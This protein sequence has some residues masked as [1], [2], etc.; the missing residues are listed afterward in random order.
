MAYK[1]FLLGLIVTACAAGIF[2]FALYQEPIDK[3]I[4]QLN[5]WAIE[6][7][8]EKVYLHLDKPYYAAG[9][10]VWFKAYVTSGSNNKLSALSGIVNVE[11]IDGSDSVKQLVKLLLKDGV[12]AGDFALPDT[13]HQGN[14][15]IRAYTNYMRNAGGEYF[16]DKSISIIN[17][18]FNAQA[19]VPAK[20]NSPK[21]I[22][23]ANAPAM[24]DVQFFPES[25][26]IVAGI[27]AKIAFKAVGT[28]GMGAAVTGTITDNNGRPVAQLSSAHL[29]MGV[30]TLLPVYGVTYRANITYANGKTNTVVLPKVMDKGYI[31]NITDADKQTLNIKISGSKSLLNQES[32]VILIAQNNGKIYYSGKIYPGDITI[33]KNILPAGIV[34]FTLFTTGGEPLNERLVFIQHPEKLKLTITSDKQT[35]APR[36]PVKIDINALNKENMPATGNFSVSVT[37]ETKVPVN[38]DDENNMMAGLLLAADLKGYIEQPAYYFNKSITTTRADL[39]VLM[40]T[41][42]YHRFEWKEV[43]NN[44]FNTNTYLPENSLQVSGMLTTPSG[45]PVVN[46][47]VKLI[48]LD[49]SS[50]TLDTVTDANGRFAF[51]DLTFPDSLRLI[52]QARTDKN[53]KD[54]VIH[55]DSIAPAN[56]FT[57]KNPGNYDI[58]ISSPLAV[59]GQSSRELYLSQL[60]Y[61]IGNHVI[62]LREVI[63]REKKQALK[64]SSN[65]NGPGN[66]DQVLLARDLKNLG[67]VQITDCLQGRLLGVIFRNGVPYSTRSFYRPMQVIVDGTYVDAGFLNNINYND[68][69]AI[70]VLRNASS[71]SIYGGRGGNGVIIVTTKRGGDND[72]AYDGPVSGRGIKVFYPKGYYKARTFYSPRYDK[73]GVNKQ[74]AD[75]RTTIFWKPDVLTDTDGKASFGYFNAGTKGNYRIVIEGIDN[76]GNLG[77]QVYRY[78]VE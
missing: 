68:V 2:G 63:I 77:R 42:G 72:N 43:L 69:Q 75:L 48:D 70:E 9:D 66:A 20:V 59:Y 37:D 24:P 39:D 56:T 74:L 4:Q 52:V 44:R 28:D 25:G 3:I 41:Q 16:F 31:L 46:G 38:G 7:P 34:Q 6:H 67:C 36:Q 23:S 61:G 58:S 62:P 57:G 45:R 32:G 5:K 55:L 50:F 76:E 14:Y 10:D 53:K 40:L 65:L 13:L 73:A 33:D 64:N 18:T 26:S 35:Y 11:L 15:R 30:F 29:G 49:D 71:A 60:K 78:R 47:K 8:V 22:V 51:T 17:T 54:V 1:R 19:K 12:A 27:Q 21:N